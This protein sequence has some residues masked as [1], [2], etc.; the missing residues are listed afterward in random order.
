MKQSS[1]LK[2]QRRELEKQLKNYRKRKGQLDD[3]H[4]DLNSDFEDY[5]ADISKYCGRVRSN[6]NAGIILEGGSTTPENLFK[7][8]EGIGDYN[9]SQSRSC[10]IA[11]KNS[12]NTKI[13]ELESDVSRLGRSIQVAED[14]EREELRQKIEEIFT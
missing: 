7:N 6:M 14:Q 4:R 12:V 5:A 10:I 11:E 9:L 1:I 13:S 3:I 2:G 8:E